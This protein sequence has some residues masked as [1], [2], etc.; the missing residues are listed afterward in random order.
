MNEHFLDIKSASPYYIDL[1]PLCDDKTVLKNPHKGWYMHYIDNG[2]RRANYRNSIE[3]GDY[4]EDFPGLNHLYLRIDWSDIEKE[5]GK[6]DWS[7][8][9]H[10]FDEWGSRG[11]SFAFRLCTYEGKG[12]PNA[13]PE[14]VREAGADVTEIY[15]SW[16]PNYG[17]PVYL[18]KL[19]SFMRCFGAKYNSDPRVEFIDIGTYGTWGEGHTFAGS[20]K[21]YP[22]EVLRR[23]VDIHLDNFPDKFLLVNDDMI[24]SAYLAGGVGAAEYLMDYCAGKGLGARDDSVCV[25]SYA[26]TMGYDTMRYGFMYDHFYENA[27]VDLE[28]EHYSAVSDEVFK[29]GYVFMEA[30][31]RAHATYAGFHGNPRYWLSQRRYFTEYI[32]NRLGYWYFIDSVELPECVSGYSSVAKLKIRNCGYAPAYYRYSLKLKA[33]PTDGAGD[34]LLF[35]GGNNLLWKDEFTETVKLSFKCVPAGRYMLKLGLFEG[36][37]PIKFAIKDKY[38]NNGW[39]DITAFE[40]KSRD[41]EI[42]DS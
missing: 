22:V 42:F 12:V 34:Y 4:L 33:V 38:Y 18:R 17:D 41:T 32:A 1:R 15:D 11:Y 26:A 10:I 3:K 14:W 24:H 35:E 20:A 9:N 5:E 2:M 37:T 28:F 40:V 29:D 13:T 6:Y 27:P 31:K 7:E 30:L 16:E 23:H 36:K 19:A 8:I 21:N 25:S 39:Y